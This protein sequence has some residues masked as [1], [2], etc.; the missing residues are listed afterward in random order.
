MVTRSIANLACDTWTIRNEACGVVTESIWLDD[1]LHR[2]LA[3]LKQHTSETLQVSYQLDGTDIDGD[4][5]QVREAIS[6]VQQAYQEAKQ[7]DAATRTSRYALLTKLATGR[8]MPSEMGLMLG[9]EMKIAERFAGNEH[10]AR[11]SRLIL[12]DLKAS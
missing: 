10:E 9:I 6:W 2:H 11:L 12:H 8:V 4:V 1:A 5:R 3:E 7:F